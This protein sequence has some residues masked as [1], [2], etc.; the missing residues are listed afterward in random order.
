MTQ[1]D[2]TYFVNIGIAPPKNTTDV[3]IK[4]T[5]DVNGGRWLLTWLLLWKPRDGSE[6]AHLWRGAPRPAG[7]SP[8]PAPRRQTER[9]RPGA[10]AAAGGGGEAESA[11]RGA[12][13]R[14]RVLRLSEETQSQEARAAGLLSVYTGH[15]HP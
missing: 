2:S 1:H 5:V 10:A 8:Q 12:R 14:P 4:H 11:P 15:A 13:E 3:M 6:C 7:V 9:A